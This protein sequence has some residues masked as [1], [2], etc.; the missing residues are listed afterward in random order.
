MDKPSEIFSLVSSSWIPFL[1]DCDRWISLYSNCGNNT[2]TMS[3]FT[4]QIE[5]NH[6]VLPRGNLVNYDGVE[7]FKPL[8]PILVWFSTGF[9]L[10]IG[11]VPRKHFEFKSGLSL[12][13]GSQGFSGTTQSSHCSV[14]FFWC[15]GRLLLN[16][17]LEMD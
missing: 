1:Q 2:S 7:L 8:Y 12:S 13:V 15:R 11:C 9:L 16:R 4:R 6:F 17:L 14:L 3:I 10:V 5:F